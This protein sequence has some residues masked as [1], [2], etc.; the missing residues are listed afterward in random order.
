MKKKTLHK[1]IYFLLASIILCAF[2]LF[3]MIYTIKYR[4]VKTYSLPQENG[5]TIV[6]NDGDE[7]QQRI[8]LLGNRLK[9]ITLL[10]GSSADI[11]QLSAKVSYQ[12]GDG[13]VT[14]EKILNGDGPWIRFDITPEEKIKAEEYIDITIRDAQAIDINGNVLPFYVQFAGEDIYENPGAVY[15][16][17]KLM[18]PCMVEYMMYDYSSVVGEI[19]CLS[20]TMVLL[21]ILN[22]YICLDK[23]KDNKILFLLCSFLIFFVMNF[24]YPLFGFRG[25]GF[26]ETATDFYKN[27]HEKDFFSNLFTLESGNY[28]SIFQRI[29]AYFVVGILKLKKSAMVV[30]Q[31]FALLFISVSSSLICL[32]RFRKYI[33]SHFAV[34]LSIMLAV[35]IMPFV[36]SWYMSIGYFGI[37]WILYFWFCELEDMTTFKYICVCLIAAMFCLSKMLYVVIIPICILLFLIHMKDTNK[38]RPIYMIV[39][40]VSCFLEF[41]LTRYVQYINGKMDNS[42]HVGN[43]KD[44]IIKVSYG[45]VQIFNTTIFRGTSAASTKNVIILSFIIIAIIYCVWVFIKKFK[46]N[47]EQAGIIIGCLGVVIACVGVSILSGF[48]SIDNIDWNQSLYMPTNQHYFFA[49]IAIYCIGVATLYWLKLERSNRAMITLIVMLAISCTTDYIPLSR[50]IEQISCDERQVRGDWKSYSQLLEEETYGIMVHYVSGINMLYL[51]DSNTQEIVLEDKFTNSVD[52]SLLNGKDGITEIYIE[53]YEYTN[54]LV[55]RTVWLSFE[56]EDGNEICKIPQLNTSQSRLHLGYKVDENIC[57]AYRMN[58]MD[59]EENPVYI[60]GDV[61]VVYSNK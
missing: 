48:E 13:I 20:V 54:Q 60:T 37:L 21:F 33:E 29:V 23:Q 53:K 4:V 42:I 9:N 11:Y 7:L 17:K 30:L 5:Q 22:I 28:L 27:A 49:V 56:D 2:V 59:D 26:G 57:K 55:E 38:R 14:E 18:G 58:V 24:Y 16:G 51:K 44:L 35:G 41:F 39:L 43:I 46:S 52:L 34:M 45:T 50:G 6:L 32:P 25:E 40:I 19:V 31:I 1:K 61:T 47:Y 36:S 3:G 12:Y 15:N 8:L 10:C